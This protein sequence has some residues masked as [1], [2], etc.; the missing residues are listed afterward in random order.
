MIVTFKKIENEY[1]FS[2]EDL[3]SYCKSMGIDT[4]KRGSLNV[5]NEN[6]FTR[7]WNS[8]KKRRKMGQDQK[9]LLRLGK[10]GSA[11]T[12]AENKSYYSLRLSMNEKALKGLEGNSPSVQQKKA[13]IQEIIKECK[14][15]I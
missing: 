6:Q 13:E 11:R 15:N 10:K 5:L 2:T 1:G 14:A 8:G 9:D 4:D 7:C 3:K 12:S